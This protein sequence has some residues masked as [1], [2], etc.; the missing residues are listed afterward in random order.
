[1]G[2]R[3]PRLVLI[4][5]QSKLHPRFQIGTAPWKRYR[6]RFAAVPSGNM[7]QEIMR[8]LF[9]YRWLHLPDRNHRYWVPISHLALFARAILPI[10][11]WEECDGK[12]RHNK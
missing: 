6:A 8:A 5:L 12:C 9:A 7:E 10:G 11:H 1:M 2:L 4:I 3:T